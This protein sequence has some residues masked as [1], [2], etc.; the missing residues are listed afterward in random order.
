MALIF[1]VLKW[2]FG[3]ISVPLSILLMLYAG[4]KKDDWTIVDSDGVVLVDKTMGITLIVVWTV[5]GGLFLL[6]EYLYKRS[7]KNKFK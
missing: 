6:F 4:L 2:I 7:I 1:K 5:I 3:I